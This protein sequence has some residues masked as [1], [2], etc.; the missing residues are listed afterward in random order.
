MN[1]WT[2]AIIVAS[3]VIG[4]GRFTIPGHEL[5]YAGSYE[6]FAHIWVGALIVFCFQ[7]RTR[8]VAIACLAVITVLEIVKFLLR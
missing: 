8:L 4:L 1:T 5:S 3:I 2:V 7:S 6:A